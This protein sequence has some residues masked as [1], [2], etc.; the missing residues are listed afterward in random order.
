[1]GL[2]GLMGHMGLMGPMELYR[3]MCNHCR[4]VS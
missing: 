4:M 3:L 2:I 1:M